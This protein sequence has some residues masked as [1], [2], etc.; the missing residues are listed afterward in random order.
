M[1]DPEGN[2]HLRHTYQPLA[3]CRRYHPSS[4]ESRDHFYHCGDFYHF[5]GLTRDLQYTPSIDGWYDRIDL[6]V[7]PLYGTDKDYK[8]ASETAAKFGG[9][10]AGDVVPGHT[11][12]TICLKLEYNQIERALH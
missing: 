4:E 1:G 10:I 8:K 12:L 7:D 2:R 11:V 9:Y 6:H 3:S 5:I